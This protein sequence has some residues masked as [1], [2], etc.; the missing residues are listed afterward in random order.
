VEIN[1][2]QAI[3]TAWE[4]AAPTGRAVARPL[5]TEM[6]APTP[7]PA[8]QPAPARDEQLLAQLAAQEEVAPPPPAKPLTT[9]IQPFD[10]HPLG[11]AAGRYPLLGKML[12]DVFGLDW[13][14]GPLGGP[15]VDLAA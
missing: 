2:T 4:S 12:E 10:L 15:H 8:P 9:P 1:S 5:L 13:S 6:A 14:E 3:G 11:S 7:A